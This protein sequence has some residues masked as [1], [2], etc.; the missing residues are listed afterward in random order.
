MGALEA[1]LVVS[2]GNGLSVTVEPRKP[3]RLSAMA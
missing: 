3:L 1:P 2:Y